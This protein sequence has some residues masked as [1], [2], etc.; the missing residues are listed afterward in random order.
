MACTRNRNGKYVLDAE[1]VEDVSGLRTALEKER[2]GRSELEK[3]MN[4]LKAQFDG[5]DPAK[6]RDALE[7]IQKLQDKKLI[8]EGKLEEL[9]AHRTERLRA[10]HEN[11]I[12]AFNKQ[13]EDGK[14]MSDRLTAQLSEL[15]IDNAVRSAAGKLGVHDTAIEDAVLHA[16]T[17]YR[18]RTGAGVELQISP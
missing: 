10:D 11:Q 5:L 1:V 7:Q 17:R 3:A 15:L 18:S 13:L 16:K 2:G 14:G 8:D 6:A 9:L 12:K 4:A